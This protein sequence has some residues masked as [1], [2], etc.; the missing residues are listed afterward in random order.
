M[1]P[2]LLAALALV[3]LLF[4]LVSGRSDRVGITAPMVFLGLGILIGNAGIGW[5]NAGV[6]EGA[7][8]GLAE[9]TLVLVLFTDASRID[10]SSLRREGSLPSRLLGF[11]LPLTILAGGLTA[12]AVFPEFS[13]AS[14]FLL[15]AILAPTDAALGQ[16]VISSSLVPVRIRQTLNVESGLNDGIVLP[17]ILILATLAGA[18]EGGETFTGWVRFVALQVTLGPLVGVGVG[19]FG[20]KLVDRATRSGWMNDSFQRLA[21]IALSVL[22]FSGAEVMGGNGFIAAFVAGMTIGNTSRGICHCLF[23][24]GEAEGQFLTLLVFMIF[25]GIMVP[26]AAR[27]WDGSA[28]LYAGLSLTVVRMVPVA[29]SLLGS[30][31]RRPSVGFLGWFGPRGL[32]SILFTLLCV[33]ELTLHGGERLE[34]IV[35]L[36]VLLSTVAHG[37]TAYPLA[38]RYGARVD[39]WDQARAETAPMAEMPVRHSM[40]SK[41]S[42]S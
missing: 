41:T 7:V 10:L 28:W 33:D 40:R 29:I 6:A 30:G 23:E 2:Q 8:H 3:L 37:I 17:I 32:A 24:F 13:I 27:H 11:G 34:A 15:A 1:N 16:A 38:R 21:V 9:L 14:A 4:G 26:Q 20:G 35:Y 5:L 19:Y 18:H 42:E 12:I 39:A 36:T 22:A 25:G 31:L